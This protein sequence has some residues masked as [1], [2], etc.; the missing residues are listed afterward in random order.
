MRSSI[1]IASVLA[2]FALAA[3][4]YNA[5]DGDTDA[6]QTYFELLSSTVQDSQDMATAPVCDLSKA[7]MPSSKFLLIGFSNTRMLT[8]NST[9]LTTTNWAHSK[10]RCYRAR[11][12]ELHLQPE[13]RNRNTGV[14]WCRCHALQR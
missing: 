9:R 5:A 14:N 1:W 10:T 3:P 7:Q 12:T 8:W 4:Q 2:T 13:Q 11:C 6:L